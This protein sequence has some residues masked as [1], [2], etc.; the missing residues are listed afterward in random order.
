MKKIDLVLYRFKYK[1]EKGGRFILDRG[2]VSSDEMMEEDQKMQA[3]CNLDAARTE[4]NRYLPDDFDPEKELEEAR[5]Q[6][7]AS[8]G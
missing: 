1:M 8:F 4:I 2:T 5:A 3:L 7:Y 6:R